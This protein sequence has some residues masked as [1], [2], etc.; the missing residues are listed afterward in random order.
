MVAAWRSARGESRLEL[1][2]ETELTIRMDC[3]SI[4]NARATG[5]E[6]SKC[7]VYSC[8]DGYTV[9]PDRQTCIKKGTVAVAPTPVVETEQVV[10]A[11]SS[12]I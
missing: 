2:F 5:C 12:S 7:A 11:E 4:A 3:S 1:P 9:S 8:F 6:A 10:L